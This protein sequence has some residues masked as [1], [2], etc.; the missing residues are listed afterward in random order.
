MFVEAFVDPEVE[1]PTS[2]AVTFRLNRDGS[3][4]T[5]IEGSTIPNGI[6]WTADDK[7]MYFV[8]TPA[9]TIYAYDFDSTAGTISDRRVHLH[10]AEEGVYPDGHAMDVEGN[11][12][13]ACFGGGKVIR[14]SSKGEI[15]GVVYLPT[16]S[17]TCPTFVGTELFITSA[18]EPDPEKYPESAM[19]EGNLFKVDVGIQGMPKHKA[20]LS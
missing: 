19:N 20:R 15:T 2:E 11:I 17:I 4:K 5:L 12:W 8:E 3:L 9:Q 6:S 14:I 10:L 7:T 13:Q 18:K 16:R 1:E